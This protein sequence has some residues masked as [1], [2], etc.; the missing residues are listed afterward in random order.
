M[1]RYSVLVGQAIGTAEVG[2]FDMRQGG[3]ETEPSLSQ[4]RWVSEIDNPL[5]INLILHFVALI[6]DADM[7]PMVRFQK[8]LCIGVFTEYGGSQ[9]LPHHFPISNLVAAVATET[10]CGVIVASIAEI[11]LTE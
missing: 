6:M 5:T 9:V 11:I 10:G 1:E 4:R 2:D 7:I 8:M 3:A